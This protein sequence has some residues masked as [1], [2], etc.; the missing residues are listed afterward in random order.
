MIA[1]ASHVHEV[2]QAL[3]Q[4][5]RRDLLTTGIKQDTRTFFEPCI[6]GKLPRCGVDDAQLTVVLEATTIFVLCHFVVGLLETAA[7]GAYHNL[8]AVSIPAVTTS[9][10][11]NGDVLVAGDV[12]LAQPFGLVQAAVSQLDEILCGGIADIDGYTGRK[13][14]APQRRNKLRAYGTIQTFQ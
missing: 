11:S 8:H 14:H 4:L 5:V 12:P 9:T 3:R 10:R 2:L 13:R 1:C 6:V 7:L